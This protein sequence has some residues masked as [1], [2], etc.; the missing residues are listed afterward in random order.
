MK[1]VN[2]KK[3]LRS[4]ILIIGLVIIFTVSISNNVSFS[5]QEISFKE[6]YASS[7]DT[8]WTLAKNESNTNSYYLDKDLRYI[9]K[10]IKKFNNLETSELSVGQKI[11][12]PND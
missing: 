4:I 1:I 9:V 5:K 12:I 6:I 8:L 7:G 2:C 10:D 3:F 11:L